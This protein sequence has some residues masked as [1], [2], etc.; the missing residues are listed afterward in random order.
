MD[1][2]ENFG[3]RAFGVYALAYSHQSDAGE[4][5]ALVQ[6]QG[7]RQLS[8]ESGRV[9]NQDRIEGARF[10]L[11]GREKALEADSFRA[12][13]ADRMVRV[14]VPLKNYPSLSR[15]VLTTL[16]DLVFDGDGGL[17]VTAETR[18]DGAAKVHGVTLA[19]SLLFGSN[20]A[21]GAGVSAIRF[22]PCSARN[23]RASAGMI[24]LSAHSRSARSSFAPSL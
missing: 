4:R 22:A 3:L 16:S 14:D 7:I 18:I 17:A 1:A 8:S 15:C 23:S 6:V 19:D 10:L 11:C 12:C 9:V 2:E 24:T 5:Q 21:T 13:A 20:C